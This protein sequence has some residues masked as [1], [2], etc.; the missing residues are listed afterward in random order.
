MTMKISDVRK[1]SDKELQMILAEIRNKLREARFKAASR[2]LKNYK[3]LRIFKHDIAR[4]LTVIN[5]RRHA[6]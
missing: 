2:Q 5:E 3:E 6:K 1:K 4:I